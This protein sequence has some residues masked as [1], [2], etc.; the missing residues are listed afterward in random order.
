MRV[1][2]LLTEVLTAT[3]DKTRAEARIA[4]LRA[5]LDAEARRRHAEEGAA[6][7]WKARGLGA[8]RLD[9]ADAPLA[10]YVDDP[11]AVASYV[12]ERA[13]SETVATITVPAGHLEAALEALDLG[14]VV[15]EGSRVEVR[16]AYLERLLDELEAID[17]DT[18]ADP[19]S[20]AVVPGVRATRPAARLVVALDR[21]AK[22]RVLAEVDAELEREETALADELAAGATADTVDAATSVSP[23]VTASPGTPDEPVLVHDHAVGPPAGEALVDELRGLVRDVGNARAREHFTGDA[24]DRE[25]AR[26]DTSDAPHARASTRAELERL[27]RPDLERHATGL[28]ISRARSRTK[29]DLIDLILDTKTAETPNTVSA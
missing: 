20:G 1:D 2:R 13:P 8:V 14:G 12:A 22:A 19:S 17:A 21:D 3:A 9:G 10:P 18:V 11:E 23:Q 16:P 5:V 24:L 28:G 25:L 29:R 4:R 26:E 7:S 6:P 15:V 27:H